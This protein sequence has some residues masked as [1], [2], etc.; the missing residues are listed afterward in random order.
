[1]CCAWEASNQLDDKSKTHCKYCVEVNAFDGHWTLL[2][3]NHF[4]GKYP[5]NNKSQTHT[6]V[7]ARMNL[8]THTSINAQIKR[9]DK[10]MYFHTPPTRWYFLFV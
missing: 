8:Y 6:L 10:F 1:M 4:D 5:S 9:M 2:M 3:N 7:Q